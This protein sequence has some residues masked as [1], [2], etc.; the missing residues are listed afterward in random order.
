MVGVEVVENGIHALGRGRYLL[1]DLFQEV[2][3]VGNRAPRVVPGERL[4]SGRLERAEDV[5]LAAPAIVNLL[6]GSLSRTLR[7]VDQAL[8]GERLGRLGAHLVQADHDAT[9]WWLGVE[10]LNRPLLAAN[11]GSTRWPNQVSCVRQRNPSRC[12]TSWMRLRLIAR[13]CLPCR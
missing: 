6:L 4:P 2:D 3:P 11:S 5:A 8:A 13:P 10:A 7:R 9:C 1:V 12:N